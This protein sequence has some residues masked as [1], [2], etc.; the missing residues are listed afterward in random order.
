MK[1]VLFCGGF[2]T[3]IR[4][5]SESIP[6]PMIPVGHYPILWHIMSYYSHYGHHDFI[7]CLGYQANIIKRYFL[8]L[9][10]ESYSD[11]VISGNGKHVEILGN[12][13][14]AWR[15]TLADTGLHRNIGQRL[16]AVRHLVQ[17]EEIFLANYSDALTDALLPDVLE[18]FK[19]SGK[20]ACFLAIR[21]SF[22]FHT[23][24]FDEAGTVTRFCSSKELDMWVNGGYFIFRN[25]IYDYIR[26]G[27]ELVL[28]PFSR[29]IKDG[30]LSAYRHQGFWR[31]MD[32]LNDKRI[33][34]EMVERGEMPWR[35]L[36]DA[37]SR[38]LGSAPK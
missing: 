1:V 27:E 18:D 20:V 9:R 7:L 38:S 10:P 13:R 36:P 11:C 8:D 21:P 3:R 15:V 30:Q 25:E 2:G 14:P 4:E 24:E 32:T 16:L 6:K 19:K 5:Y 28:E 22:N 34:E 26:E 23:T 35:D 17:N 29:L 12:E 33:L 37:P 31:A